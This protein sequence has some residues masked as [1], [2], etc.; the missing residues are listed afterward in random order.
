MFTALFTGIHERVEDG[1]GLG[2]D[3]PGELGVPLYR[4]EEAMT[5]APEGL[6]QAVGEECHGP[7]P[8][9]EFAHGLVMVAVYA[10][11]VFPQ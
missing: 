4:P 5:R 8:R 10:E 6:H 7:K 11:G 9:R 2:T 1:P 3:L